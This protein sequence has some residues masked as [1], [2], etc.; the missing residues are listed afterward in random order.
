[1]SKAKTGSHSADRLL[2]GIDL[3][4]SRS[5]VCA[6]NGERAWVDSYVGY[7]KDFVARRV[8]GAPVLFGE[9]ALANRQS[10]DLYRPLEHGVI[11]EGSSRNE[12]A[13][14]DLARHLISLV[15]PEAGQPVSVA[16]GV[17]AESFKNNKLAIKRCIGD[18]ADALM[19]VSEPFAVAYGKN[20]LKDALIIDI[21]GGT[22]DF[23]IMRG[24]MPGDDDQRTLATAGDYIDEKLLE[25]L[26]E[27]YPKSSVTLNMARRFKE[28][29]SFVGEP[30][31]TV[32]V[33]IPVDGK[34]TKHDITDEIRAA[35]ES[36]LPSVVESAAEMISRSDP[37]FQDVVRRN[38]VLAGG[39]S[40]V[41]GLP[42]YLQRELGAYGPCR[43]RIV[44][45]VLY[46]GAE[47]CLA[48]ATDMPAEYWKD[49]AI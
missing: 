37:E 45:D 22:I 6:S 27:R 11:R 20:L 38:I 33:D 19:V 13:I 44:D 24:S 26:K 3:G 32:L 49:V 46:A 10:L 18:A 42:E 14:A 2:L 39:G 12:Q 35:C 43:V 30:E 31:D 8:L 25:A 16:V 17:P 40:Q 15:N 4:T 41:R 28:Q 36:V 48:L 7:P 1:M 5:V 47:G 23:C 21:G 34:A 29:F 9:A